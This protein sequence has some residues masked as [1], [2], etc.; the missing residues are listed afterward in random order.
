M[1]G[2]LTQLAKREHN[3]RA[4]DMVLQADI[5]NTG[6]AAIK[7]GI[8]SNTFSWQGGYTSRPI[9]LQELGESLGD[10]L[11]PIY[12]KI[13]EMYKLKDNPELAITLVE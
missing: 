13:S 11:G 8:S 12:H 10:V 9:D 7:V 1:W 3:L 2:A 6:P 5:S 4:D